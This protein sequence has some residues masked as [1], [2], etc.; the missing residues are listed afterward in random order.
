MKHLL[1]GLLFVF[2]FIVMVIGTLFV[3]LGGFGDAPGYMLG[4][5]FACALGIMCSIKS[6]EL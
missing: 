4:G 5:M 1:K 2:G 3:I 6:L